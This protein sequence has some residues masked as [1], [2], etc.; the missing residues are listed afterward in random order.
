[1]IEERSAM[2]ACPEALEAAA[3][4][5]YLCGAYG[6]H[7]N[8]VEWGDDEPGHLEFDRNQERIR[9]QAAIAEFCRVEGLIVESRPMLVDGER[10]TTNPRE[11]HLV[12]KWREVK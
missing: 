6:G 12:G 8:P 10:R 9:A 3:R 5:I 11:W 2:E 4:A 1:M 7:R